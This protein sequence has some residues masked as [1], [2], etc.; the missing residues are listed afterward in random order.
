MLVENPLLSYI[1]VRHASFLSPKLTVGEAR[2]LG[3]R[4]T[5]SDEIA[6]LRDESEERMSRHL[7]ELAHKPVQEEVP[8]QEPTQPEDPVKPEAPVEEAEHL[9]VDV[10]DLSNTEPFLDEDMVTQKTMTIDLFVPGAR[11]AMQQ[12]PSQSQTQAPP[13]PPPPQTE[14]LWKRQRI[15]EQT[16]TGP[17][18][19]V[20]RTPPRPTGGI[21]IH[22]LQTQVGPGVASSSQATQAWKPKFLL[23]GKPLPSTA[24]VRMWEKGEGGRIAQTL[25]KGLLLLDDVHAFEEVSE[26]SMG[27]R[28]QWHTVTVTLYLLVLYCPLHIHYFSFTFHFVAVLIFV[29]V[30]PLN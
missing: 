1:D 10:T 5:Y 24:C 11:Q 20:V 7:R 14:R 6:P 16:T 4:Y 3:K 2:K 22:E 27:R 18:D 8:V 28:L 9:V 19:A 15:A 17:R 23:D 29:F 21:V 30:R 26:E 25:A 12:P 13:S